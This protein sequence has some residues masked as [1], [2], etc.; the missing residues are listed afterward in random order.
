M[1][2]RGRDIHTTNRV[3]GT[4]IQ[5]IPP[6]DSGVACQGN[7][8]ADA[9]PCV[10]DPNPESRPLATSGGGNCGISWIAADFPIE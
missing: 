2:S 3:H 7:K 10:R 1:E 8:K 6:G 4:P 5:K 9:P